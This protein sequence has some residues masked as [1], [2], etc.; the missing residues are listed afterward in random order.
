MSYVLIVQMWVKLGKTIAV[1]RLPSLHTHDALK[2]CRPS[3]VHAV[4]PL[5]RLPRAPPYVL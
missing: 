3:V 1:N 4:S 5:F 2:S